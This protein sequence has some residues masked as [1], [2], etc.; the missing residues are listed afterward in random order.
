MDLKKY[1][2]SGSKKRDLSSETSTSSKDHKKIRDGSLDDDDVN[3][4]DDVF[5][6]GLSSPDRAKILYNCIKNVEN[7]ILAIHSKTEETKMNQIK[8]EQHLMD[9]IKTVNFIFEKFDEYERDRAEK[10]KIISEL[11]KNVNDMS[12]KIESLEGYLDRQQQSSRRSHG[13]PESKN[14]NLDEMVIESI[15]EKIREEIEKDEI[16]GSHRLDAP[17]N[18]GQADQSL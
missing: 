13:L 1:F 9:L 2:N 15:K 12:E 17:K 4:P 6:E 5:T 18:N 8:G 10:E 11:Q 7:H 14:K 16:D 3:N